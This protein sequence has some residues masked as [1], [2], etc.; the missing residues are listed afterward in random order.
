MKLDSDYTGAFYI[1]G[2][3]FEKLNEIEKSIDDF[4]TVLEIDPC[5][6]NAA[7][8]R[9]ACENKIGNY[10]KAIE[11]YN[12]ALQLDS[13]RSKFGF[14]KRKIMGDNAMSYAVPTSNEQFLSA[15]KARSKSH[16]DKKSLDFNMNN[17]DKISNIDL[18]S[19]GGTNSF[20]DGS[21]N[22]PSIFGKVRIYESQ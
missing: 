11:D 20:I 22:T 10:I 7:F 5:H 17:N 15:S 13:E 2:L 18:I 19:T 12:M 6:V 4:T 8:A 9:A 1:R 14:T 21:E 16:H 3:A